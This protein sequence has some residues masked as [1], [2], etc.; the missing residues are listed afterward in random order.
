MPLV[1]YKRIIAASKR[2]SDV[3]EISKADPNTLE[4]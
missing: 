1:E 3:I 4:E 2:V